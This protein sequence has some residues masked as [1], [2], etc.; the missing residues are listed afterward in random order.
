MGPI[1]RWISAWI[2]AEARRIAGRLLMYSGI[3]I[4]TIGAAVTY[5]SLDLD[6]KMR[7]TTGKITQVQELCELIG[8]RGRQTVSRDVMACSAI[9]DALQE[10]DV[11]YIS[12][13]NTYATVAYTDEGGHPHTDRVNTFLMGDV[14]VGQTLKIQY[15][16]DQPGKILRP[17]FGR[18]GLTGG[19]MTLIIG[20]LMLVG[21][22]QLP[23]RF[24]TPLNPH[25]QP[26]ATAPKP[27]R[28]GPIQP[29]TLPSK[30][31]PQPPA[32]RQP[33]LAAQPSVRTAKIVQAVG[34][35]RM[36]RV[37]KP[38]ARQA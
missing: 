16:S 31:L 33:G 20:G 4:F 17:L 23:K 25:A 6:G 24:H 5:T 38:A 9:D 13:E 10:E 21:W 28:A 19:T 22:W 18:Y 7:A 26:V 37:L 34:P 15:R 11:D 30:A 35:Q 32:V 36:A 12:S 1:I 14:T 2:I 8:K 29:P 27:T 3:A